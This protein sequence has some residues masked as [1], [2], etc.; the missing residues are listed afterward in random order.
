[1]KVRNQADIKQKNKNLVL[2][3][4]L[5]N[6]PISRIELAK[7][8]GLT[9]MTLSNIVSEL[10]E[11]KLVEETGTTESNL[12]RKP[13]GLQ[14]YNHFATILGIYISRD[15]IHT[16][17]GDLSGNIIF[18]NQQAIKKNITKDT[19]TEIITELMD[20]TVEQVYGRKVVGIGI[21]SVGPLDSK[22]GVILNPPNF[23]NINN[24]SLVDILRKKYNIPVFMDNDMNTSA[25]A[26]KYFG[27]AKNVA[28]FI[29]MGVTNG[30]GAGI[31]INHKLFEGDMGF[32]GEVGHITVNVDG[33]Q[34][35][36]G[37]TGCLELYTSLPNNFKDMSYR[38]QIEKIDDIGRY[39]SAG[40]VTL[41]NL[42]DP[43]QIFLGH[44]IAV[45]GE[46]V[47]DLLN[48]SIKGKYLTFGNKPV[49]IEISAFADRSPIKGSIA[50]CL[51]RLFET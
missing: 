38:R 22:R 25:L 51:E 44:D 49:N 20:A 15:E 12:G 19:L 1:M 47:S 9:K 31:V 30:V 2:K 11:E 27:K 7:L 21:S 14:V 50:L 46:Y 39:L 34:C 42:F 24:L 33:L 35:S 43:A 5:A 3:L 18:S 28:D 32:S 29:Y 36:C 6:A 41:I 23:Y 37:N 45:A 40:I 10:I 48:N 16:F 13:I 17:A 26:E 8:T 4:I